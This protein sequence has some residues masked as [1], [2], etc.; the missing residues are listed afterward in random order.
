MAPGWRP[1]D[2]RVR[3]AYGLCV[4]ERGRFVLVDPG[5]GAWNLPGGTLESGETP[6]HALVREVREEACATVQRL[7]YLASQHVWDGEAG[8]FQSRWWA[9]VRL[10]PWQPR[11]ETVGRQ[12]V[13]ADRLV[14]TLSWKHKAI[15]AR[16][17][18]SA[19]RIGV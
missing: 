13:A 6:E 2:D 19:L 12:E 1:P 8:Y 10:D 18:E 4:T 3:Q 15:A 14:E 16:L 11:H 7:E 17:L 9:R 5:G